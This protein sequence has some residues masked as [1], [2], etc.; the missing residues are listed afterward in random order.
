MTNH[1]QQ[2]LIAVN[3]NADLHPNAKWLFTFIL[4]SKWK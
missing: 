1:M 3:E 2:T 4:A